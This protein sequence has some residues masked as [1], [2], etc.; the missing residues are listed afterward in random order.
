MTAEGEM[1]R[2]GLAVIGVAVLHLVACT[3]YVKVRPPETQAERARLMETVAD[4]GRIEYVD[5]DRGMVQASVAG[6]RLLEDKLVF[7]ELGKGPHP[8]RTRSPPELLPREIAF[9]KAHML[10]AIARDH[11]CGAG[12]GLLTGLG[13]GLGLVVVSAASSG[14][15]RAGEGH[16]DC[17]MAK[18]IGGI[19]VLGA[20]AVTGLVGALIGGIAGCTSYITL[21]APAASTSGDDG[22]FVP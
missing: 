10:Q 21:E 11:G 4:S 17:E 5:P 9:E 14:S 16:S 3:T 20:A 18:G 8:G 1:G 22:A 12:M 2:L 6:L 19:I 15:C 7:T 13:V